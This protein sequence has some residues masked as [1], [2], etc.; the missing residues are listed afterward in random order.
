MALKLIQVTNAYFL[1]YTETDSRK[2]INSP[3]SFPTIHQQNE[4]KMLEFDQLFVPLVRFVSELY[5][6]LKYLFVHDVKSDRFIP[7]PNAS[8]ARAGFKRTPF[9]S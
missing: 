6:E 8:L 5:F 2:S 9:N 3:S 1:S 7:I 4:S